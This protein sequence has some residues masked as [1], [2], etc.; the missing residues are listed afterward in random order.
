MRFKNSTFKAVFLGIM[1]V[2]LVGNIYSLFFYADLIPLHVDEGGFF[3]HF[4]N[5][6]FQN[7]FEIYSLP[8][9]A[10]PVHSL[11]IYLAKASLWIFGKNGIGW[12]FPVILF[13]MLSGG[14][15]FYF[16]YKTAKIPLYS[17]IFLFFGGSL[18]TGGD[19]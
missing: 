5:T 7:R 13:S 6:L 14:I 16:V 9:G 1:L 19:C 12:R 18:L 15:L 8:P 2:I 11:T 10:V 4:T 3:F 17:V